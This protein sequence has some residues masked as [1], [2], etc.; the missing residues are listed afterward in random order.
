MRADGR[1]KDAI[2]HFTFLRELLLFLL[3]ASIFTS[4]LYWV[5][6]KYKSLN[7][8]IIKAIDIPVYLLS[9]Q[10]VFV[11]LLNDP[12]EKANLL[13]LNNL[14]SLNINSLI[15][16]IQEYHMYMKVLWKVL[17]TKISD[18]LTTQI[19]VESNEKLYIS[20][21]MVYLNHDH[22]MA[23]VHNITKSETRRL[24]KEKYRF[25]LESILENLP[26][27]TTVK[28]KNDNGRYLIWN[29]K[30]TEM[31][32]VEAEKIV[33]HYEEEFSR[34]MSDNFIEETDKQV[35]ETEI[36]HS[37]IKRFTN[38][39]GR[40][41]TLSF[42]KALVSYNNGKERWV[43]SSALDIT[44]LLASKEKAEESNR[45]KSA[46]LANMSHEIRTPLNAI[47][48][49][50]S[51]LSEYIQ[52]ED[53][54]EYIHIIEENNQLLLQLINDILDISRIEAGILEFIEDDMNVNDSL[55]EILTATKLKISPEITIR[56]LSGLDTCII[57]TVP[58]RVK[59]VLNN[60][61]SNAIKHTEKGYIEFGYYP[62][63][64]G[65]IRF[66]V[67]DTGSGIPFENQKDIFK[68]FVKLDSFKQGTGLGLS[69]CT[70]IA[71]KMN[72]EVGVISTPGKGSEFWFEIPYNNPSRER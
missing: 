39:K 61:L 18:K 17:D 56:L 6:Y 3:V 20:V 48:G 71:E 7:R 65:R 1:N 23:F 62:T 37:Y 8:Q 14:G 31:M 40:E 60:Y 9:R 11:K 43:V 16:D 22:V 45:L 44:E 21:R 52:D 34:F 53:A 55:E 41:Y 35:E 72:G 54:K 12:T 42:H 36:P 30:A 19:R 57:H 25:F 26:I 66:F 59:Q 4:F 27:A 64:E 51:I 28:D 38:P 49:F 2:M 68:R 58:N 69:I 13:P 32:D 50:S 24:E 15:V 46:F 47:V 63:Q 67:R 29:K 10:G 5:N 33:G 70:M